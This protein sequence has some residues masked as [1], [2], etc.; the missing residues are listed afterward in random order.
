MSPNEPEWNSDSTYEVHLPSTFTAILIIWEFLVKQIGE[1][2]PKRAFSLFGSKVIQVHSKDLEEL[3]VSLFCSGPPGLRR[4][5]LCKNKNP[6]CSVCVCA[7]VYVY[8]YVYVTSVSV[9]V[10]QCVTALS[11]CVPI[12]YCLGR[13]L[14]SSVSVPVYQS[15][16]VP[17]CQ[18]VCMSG[19]VGV[20]VAV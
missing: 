5:L 14:L 16:S 8:V 12:E 2:K 6:C 7:Y 18:C 1:C 20:R 4:S 9:S 3:L 10:C 15:V 19:S 13:V 17:Q 11:V